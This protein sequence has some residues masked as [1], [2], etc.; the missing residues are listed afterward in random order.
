MSRFDVVRE[1]NVAFA[2]AGGHEGATIM[3]RLSLVVVTC[4]DPRVDPA[5]I[6]ALG[7]GDAAVLRNAGGRITDEVVEDLAFIGQMAETAVPEGPLFE[8]AIVHH[9]Q[10]GTALLADEGVR[11]RY[12]K[13]IGAEPGA[14]GAR[15]VLDPDGTVRADVARLRASTAIPD[16]VT[17]SAHVYD[18]TTGRVRTIIEA[19]EARLAA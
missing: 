15:A 18:V 9:T 19:G 7:L 1:R 11:T 6:F 5:A 16:R 10:C 14:L 2:E 12:A 13:R 3:P 8:I 4:L 17:I